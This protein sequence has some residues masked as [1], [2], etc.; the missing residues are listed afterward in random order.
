MPK[1]TLRHPE[2]RF[3]SLMKR[4]KRSVDKAD[5]VKDV[6]D[7]EFYEKPSEIRKRNKAAARKR[8]QR[9]VE[10]QREATLQKRNY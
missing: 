2:E 5:V 3:E 9:T 1:A 10:A 6:R 7:R 4:F 8:T